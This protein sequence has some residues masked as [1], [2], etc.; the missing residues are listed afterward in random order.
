MEILINASFYHRASPQGSND[1]L[2]SIISPYVRLSYELLT[3][4][5]SPLMITTDGQKHH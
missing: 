1:T 2:D 5:V 4:S 3:L